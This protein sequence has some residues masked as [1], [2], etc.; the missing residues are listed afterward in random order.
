MA[1]VMKRKRPQK[2]KIAGAPPR[3]KAR[4]AGT[5][6]AVLFVVI[7]SVFFIIKY[8]GKTV[9]P[10]LPSVPSPAVQGTAGSAAEVQRAG[11]SAL[12][13]NAVIAPPN[14][15]SRTP[16]SV[17]YETNNSGGAPITPVFRWYV[18]NVLVQ[19]GPSN[20][21][22][23]GPYRKGASV[24]A[25]VSIADQT[26]VGNALLTPAV[27]ITNGPPE[28]TTIN[29]EPDNAAIGAVVSANPT[30][31]DPDGDPIIYTYQWK[32]NGN[33]VGAPGGERTFS[34]AGLR[35]NDIITATATYTDGTA[36]GIPVGSN[37]V[38]LQNSGPKITS[39]PPTEL[40]TG[41]YEYQVTATDPDGDRLSYRLDRFPSG[42]TINA[43]T[44]L[45]RWELTKGVMF[46]GRNEVAVAVTVDD[47][48]GGRDSQEFAIIINELYVN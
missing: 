47:S 9:I 27:V 5:I 11:S 29:L 36:A 21:L 18:D 45:V 23:P 43:S 34:T 15:T 8:S 32:V 20:A 1:V 14:P 4:M 26:A 33:P 37:S 10:G 35:K 44:G 17:V 42:M 30:G 46:T 16:L 31:T 28:V 25:E 22:Q 2:P 24:H 38:R 39:N 40:R 41:L 12:V 7:L 3:S 48:D 19:E 13:T 6:V